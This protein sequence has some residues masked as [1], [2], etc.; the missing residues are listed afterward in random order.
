MKLSVLD[1]SVIPEGTAPAA[2]L[3][4]SLDL[5]RAADRAGYHR[6]WLAEHHATPSFASPAPEIMAARIAAATTGIRVGSGGVLLPHYS[7]LKV[8]EVFRVLE[9]LDPGRIDLGVGRGTGAG[10]IESHALAPGSGSAEESDFPAKLA[11]LL[12]FLNDGFPDHHP[13]GRI[14]LMP[15]G[16]GAPQVWLLVAS[17]SSAALAAKLQLPVSIA[18]FGRPQATRATVEAY[19]AH[20]DH[21][22]GA[23]PR[24]Q[25]GVGVYCAPTLPEAEALFTS[26]RLFRLR[27]GRGILLPLPDPRTATAALAGEVEPLADEVAEWPRCVV[28][29]PEQV[30][31][32]LSSMAGELGAD[33]FMVLSTIHS[34]EHRIRSYELLSDAFGLV[35]R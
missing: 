31:K 9:A 5:A 6:Y 29:D 7:P 33:E 11:E 21:S 19:R 22:G 20:F 2:A 10:S 14:R 32:T 18:H 28:G 23:V 34:H 15:N 17:P 16:G 8:A 4:N 35:R 30:H 24:V 25:I 12:A 3:R 26:Q 1:Q 13:Y 27:M